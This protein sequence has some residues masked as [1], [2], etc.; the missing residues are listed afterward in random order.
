MATERLGGGS[1]V[2]HVSN[3]KGRHGL[4]TRADSFGL[5]N[6]QL[7]VNTQPFSN[8]LCYPWPLMVAT[9]LV[10]TLN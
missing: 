7:Q 1:L 6:V 10:N 2:D 3:T 5:H 9:Q 8:P 4:E